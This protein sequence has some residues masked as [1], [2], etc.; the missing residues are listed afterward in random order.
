MPT[1]SGEGNRLFTAGSKQ[2]STLPPSFLPSSVREWEKEILLLVPIHC[3]RCT[4]SLLALK[5]YTAGLPPPSDSRKSKL[6]PLSALRRASEGP[7]PSSMC[8][9]SD[10]YFPPF[11][12]SASPL[13]SGVTTGDDA[14]LRTDLYSSSPPLLPTLSSS[15]SRKGG[16]ESINEQRRASPYGFNFALQYDRTCIHSCGRRII[17]E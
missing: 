17:G 10:G 4:C 1:S 3:T 11:S 5:N 14:N 2:L 6:T 16:S 8:T 13:S 12:E 9:S 15:Q 7:V